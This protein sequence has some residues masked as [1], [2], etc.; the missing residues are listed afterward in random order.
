MSEQKLSI[1]IC[2]RWNK[3]TN[4]SQ[5]CVT[6]IYK[7]VNLVFWLEG[8]R[9]NGWNKAWSH[10]EIV[11]RFTQLSSKASAQPTSQV[12]IFKR[13]T[14]HSTSMPQ[15]I[16]LSFNVPLS[17]C[18]GRLYYHPGKE[19]AL[20]PHPPPPEEREVDWTPQSDVNR[21]YPAGGTK[22]VGRKL[23]SR[24]IMRHIRDIYVWM[25]LNLKDRDDKWLYTI[26]KN[27]RNSEM[28]FCV[29]ICYS[30]TT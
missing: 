22:N 15:E 1:F 16:I 6:G 29:L 19:F 18:V 4:L 24:R 3:R 21:A 30:L 17:S 25:A 7:Q 8:I 20:L 23:T 5:P 13:S 2:H 14:W 10:S 27:G 26:K 9:R 28:S 12:I 11:L